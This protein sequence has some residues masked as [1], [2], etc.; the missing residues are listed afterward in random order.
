[1]YFDAAIK[2][3]LVAIAPSCFGRIFRE[4]DPLF[5]SICVNAYDQRLSHAGFPKQ[6]AP[7][8]WPEPPPEHS[9]DTSLDYPTMDC[10]R[11]RMNDRQP[12]AM[13]L[14]PAND[15]FVG[16]F[17]QAEDLATVDAQLPRAGLRG[18]RPRSC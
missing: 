1:M 17:N 11:Q 6:P 9:E 8:C 15:G 2:I 3:R 14:K 7:D 12:L 5:R 10:C 4:A 18:R 16:E 13:P